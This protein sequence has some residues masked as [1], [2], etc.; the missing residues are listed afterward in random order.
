[1]H[2]LEPD[3][4]RTFELDPG[5]VYREVRS[6]PHPWVVHLLEVDLSRCDLGFRVEAARNDSGRLPVT[7]LARRAGP[8]ALAAV[9]GDFFTPEH[10]PL[11]VE[12]RG[13]EIR[14]RSA[15]PVFA[16]RPGH[17]PWIGPARWEGDSLRIA[18]WTMV[19][20]EPDGVTEVV[21]GY[22][23]LLEEGRWVGDL[24]QS[25]R[26]DFARQRAPRTGVGLDLEGERLWLV[27][28]DGRRGGSAEGM[29]LPELADLFRALGARSALNLDGG[30]SS[31]MVVRGEVASRPSD[32][33]GERSVVNALVLRRDRAYCTLMGPLEE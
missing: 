14:G 12:A 23:A 21:A 26:P 7:S 18:G 32:F 8:G 1:M 28:V 6:G 33:Q 5:V 24:L 30:G 29:T 10:Q 2:F 31:V 15:R 17:L 4:I 13:G 27:V 25:E 11:G 3:R 9:N 20:G 22:P 19:A 16:W